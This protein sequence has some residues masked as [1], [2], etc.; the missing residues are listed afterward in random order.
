[1]EGVGV[2]NT[3]GTS[4]VSVMVAFVILLIGIA[5]LSTSIA[6]SMQMAEKAKNTAEKM[7]SSIED[8]YLNTNF[9]EVITDTIELVEV[10]DKGEVI[11]GRLAVNISTDVGVTG[12][13]NGFVLYYFK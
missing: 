2:K 1:M 8:Y 9:D 6:T 10:N 5:M 11:S 4:M 12:E 13:E 7:D 3:K